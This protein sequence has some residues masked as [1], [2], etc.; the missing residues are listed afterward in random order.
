M[1]GCLLLVAAAAFA[2]DNRGFVNQRLVTQNLVKNSL[3][4]KAMANATIV[5][6]KNP[7][8]AC[9]IP[10]LQVEPSKAID[11]MAIPALKDTGDDKMILPT[12]PVCPA[13]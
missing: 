4:A 1:R 3:K 9:A 7:A 2:Q 6:P 5:P 13:K 8:P 12:I 11:R 10:L